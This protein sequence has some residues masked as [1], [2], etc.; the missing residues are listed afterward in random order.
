MRR[1]VIFWLV[2]AAACGGGNGTPQPQPRR[3]HVIAIDID[4]HGLA[5]LWMANAPQLR[6]L[7]ARGT[8]AYSRVVVPTHSNQNN[9]TLL[10]GQYPEGHNV[11]SNSWLS[12]AQNFAPPLNLPSLGL[13]DYAVWDHNPLRVRGDSVYQAVRRAGGHS[14]YFGQLPPFEAGADQAHLTILGASFGGTMITANLASGIMT[15]F[16]RYPKTV[17]DAYHLEGPPPAGQTYLQ[18]TV[19]QAAKFVR[20]SSAQNPLPDF[21]F[22]WDFIAIDGDPTATYGASG[23]AIVK[24]VEDFDQG[25]GDLLAALREKALLDDTNILFTLD[26]GKVDTH[27]QVA[28][29]TRGQSVSAGGTPIVA[30][31]QLAARVAA[32]GAELGITTSDYAILNEDGDA[33][34][35]ARVP[36]AGT[37]AGA[38]RQA[39]VTQALLTII[40]SGEITGLDVTRTMTADG[41]MGT[42]TFHDFRASGPN[43]ADILVYP[44]EDWT[45]NQVDPTNTAP[46]PFQEHTAF[47]YG[48]HGGFAADELYVPLIMA[49]PAFRQGALIP[50]PVEHPDVAATALAPL[51]GARLATAARGPIRAALVGDPAEALPQPAE[52]SGSRIAVL[53]ASGYGVK[54]SLAGAAASSAVIIDLAGVYEPELFGDDALAAAAQPLRDLATGGARFNDVWARSRDWPVSE[55]QMLSGGYPTVAA[56]VASAEDD[57]T[58]MVA[59]GPGLL[60]MPPVAGFIANRAAY[61][62][63]RQPTP[64]ARES[65]FEAARA[66]GLTTALVGQPDFHSLHLPPGAID[67]TV[68]T[69]PT[70]AAAALHDLR[71][72]Y[73]RLLALVALGSARSGDRRGAGAQAELTALASA[74][75]A[76]AREAEGALVAI[77][78]RG[79]TVI[80][81]PDADFYG[82]GSSRHVPLVL[83]G[84]NVR[85]GVVSGQPGSLADLP[86]TILFGLGAPAA[87]DVVNGTWAQ[88]P[89]VSGVPQPTPRS[90]TEGHALVRGFVTR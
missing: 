42:R 79:A 67:V 73:P 74:A 64:V 6:A 28:L 29:G 32:R 55:Y 50:H 68:A 36:N 4:D 45:L 72:Q 1:I 51:V 10:C 59:P 71:A 83:L 30:D 80:D 49:G 7:I 76:V 24:I 37:P 13:G 48:R 52:L 47:P 86:A 8:L 40:Q 53:D 34:I 81:D 56:L 60:Q 78:S 33:L 18:F 89:T 77:T 44:Q 17:V 69:D 66:L 61:D 65:L 27:Q 2:A 85:A 19:R 12:R 15:D 75:T 57:P 90:A 54:L 22:V 87:S 16:L 63:W 23:S 82:A 20:A 39:E 14:V 35:Y 31:G 3:P 70:G 21:M 9:I 88:G 26:H 25:L 43:Q 62:A 5:G 11:P 84:P 38:A 58:Q 46:G 41:A